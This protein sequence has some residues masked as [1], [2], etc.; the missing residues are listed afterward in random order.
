MK[1]ILTVSFIILQICGLIGNFLGLR[2]IIKLNEVTESNEDIQTEI[3]REVTVTTAIQKAESV[4]LNVETQTTENAVNRTFYENL[5]ADE[6]HLIEVVVTHEVGYF[7]K[8]YQTLVAEVIYNRIKSDYFPNTVKEVLYQKNQFT[9]IENWYSKDCQVSETTKEVVKE[10]FSK[11]K[12]THEA[13]YY[14]NP[15]YSCKTSI[16]WFEN[17]GD[18]EYLFS[19]SQTSWGITYTT[20]F[21]KHIE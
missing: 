13:T 8:E 14:Y 12:T 16:K 18:V 1:K 2:A 10:V 17:S 21:F 5:T 3:S 20:R 11:D 19:F 9:G 6:V 15:D 7:T 4:F